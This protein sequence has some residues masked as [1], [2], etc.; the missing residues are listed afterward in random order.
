MNLIRSS[1]SI[2][3]SA[4]VS[5]EYCSSVST[6]QRDLVGSFAP[7][8]Q[9]DHSKGTTTRSIPVNGDVFRVDLF[10]IVSVGALVIV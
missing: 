10:A 8:L 6:K 5:I 1:A 9:R 7:L 3:A 2:V 4:P